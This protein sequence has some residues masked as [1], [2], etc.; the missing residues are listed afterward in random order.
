MVLI[1]LVEGGLL[2]FS[3]FLRM[4]EGLLG[5]KEHFNGTKGRR[6]FMGLVLMVD[7]CRTFL[8]I[9]KCFAHINSSSFNNP[10]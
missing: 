8:N 9:Q 5:G 10:V 1:G 7:I 3:F 2:F 4:R 6:L